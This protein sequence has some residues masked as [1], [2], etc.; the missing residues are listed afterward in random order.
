MGSECFLRHS[1]QSAW[2]QPYSPL[3][4]CPM[5]WISEEGE[6][7]MGAGYGYREISKGLSLPHPPVGA[8]SHLRGSS[9]ACEQLASLRTSVPHVPGL[10]IEFILFVFERTRTA[11]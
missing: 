6:Q 9:W 10:T 8:Q 1:D 3:D 7:G 4:A 2:V 11:S 5:L